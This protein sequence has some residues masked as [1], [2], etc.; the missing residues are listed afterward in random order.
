M[1]TA[2]Y[3]D[4][5]LKP[6]EWPDQSRLQ[7]L[8]EG[9][10]ENTEDIYERLTQIEAG[11]GITAPFV[12]ALAGGAK[13]AF[14]GLMLTWSGGTESATHEIAHK[15]NVEPVVLLSLNAG[16]PSSVEVIS[17]T[18]TTFTVKGVLSST[19]TGT[20]GLEWLAVG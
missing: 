13:I 11:L 4:L 12:K 19:F 20:V 17:R 1:P 9:L 3:S 14:G 7:F 2:P 5:R 8:H 16:Q 10:A 6:G 15:L 18:K